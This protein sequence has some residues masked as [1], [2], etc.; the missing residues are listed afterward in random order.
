MSSP[1]AIVISLGVACGFWFLLP[2]RLTGSEPIAVKADRAR[3]ALLLRLSRSESLRRR[4]DLAGEGGAVAFRARQLTMSL[5]MSLAVLAAGA[6]GAIRG[7]P[8]SLKSL[9]VTALLAG[10]AIFAALDMGLSG[11]ARR[12]QTAVAAQ[13]PNIADLVCLGVV[14]GES[15]R[16]AL[17]RAAEETQGVL[18]DELRTCLGSVASGTPLVSALESLAERFA[19]APLSRFVSALALAHERGTPLAEQLQTITAEIRSEERRSLIEA[20]GKSQTRMLIPVVALIL[21]TALAFA[22]FPGFVALRAF[23]P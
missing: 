20:A 23:V 13:V 7:A 10:S 22:F 19:V 9:P 3:E 12:R 11:R 4:L 17:A 18:S 5:L 1:V 16:S 14:A 2:P 6:G 15:L 8:I 21:P